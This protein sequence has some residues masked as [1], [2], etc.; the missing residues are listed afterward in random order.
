MW[1]GNL[2]HQC[3]YQALANWALEC[4][5]ADRLLPLPTVLQVC[6]FDRFVS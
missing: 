1:L 2:T 6:E 5:S 4:Q 3:E